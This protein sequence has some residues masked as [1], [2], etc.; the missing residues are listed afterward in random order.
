M[1]TIVKRQLS[2]TLLR[3]TLCFLRILVVVMLFS[4]EDVTTAQNHSE[5]EPDKNQEG[6]VQWKRPRFADRRQDRNAM[7]VKQLQGGSIAIKDKKVVRAMRSVPRHLFV[8]KPLRGLAYADRPLPIGSGQTISQPFI[9]AYMTETLNLGPGDKVLEIGTGSGYQAAVLSEITPHVYSVE[10]I[11][12]LGRETN[13][14]L[15]ELGYETIKVKLDDGYHGWEKYAPFDAI[16]VT[17]A[18]GHVPPPL[19]KQLK[20]GGRMII[21]VGGVYDVQ[22]LIKVTKSENGEIR[23]RQLI[24]VRFVPMTGKTQEE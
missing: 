15:K 8:P 24:P 7:V 13:Q 1:E 3:K 9:V 21:P 5:K 14:I 11:K 17:C 12:K 23:S 22:M 2:F 10:I 16:L 20:P 18:A 6:H 19:V 4:V